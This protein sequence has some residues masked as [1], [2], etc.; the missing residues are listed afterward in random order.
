M[1][2]AYKS[3]CAEKVAEIEQSDIVSDKEIFQQVAKSGHHPRMFVSFNETRYQTLKKAKERKRFAEMF[4]IPLKSGKFDT[5]QTDTADKLVRL[6]CNKG[7]MDPFQQQP[8]EV[9]GARKW[10]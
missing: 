10:K 1:E 6:L 7:M 8:V 9:S 4:G 2:H 5:S 3:I